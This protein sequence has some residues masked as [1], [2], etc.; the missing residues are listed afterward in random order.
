MSK[1]NFKKN[2]SNENFKGTITYEMFTYEER[3]K[4]AQ[5]VFVGIGSQSVEDADG[6]ATEK[7]EDV[8]STTE[9]LELGKKYNAIAAS[10][11]KEVD[12][13]VVSDGEMKDTEIKSLEALCCFQEGVELVNELVN[14]ML[15]GHKLGKKQENS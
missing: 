15:G 8:M 2:V 4:K 9:Q 6:N 11:I 1:L 14:T 7:K 5:E 10:Q 13:V 12:L 3:I